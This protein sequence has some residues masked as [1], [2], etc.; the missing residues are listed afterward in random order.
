MYKLFYKISIY[1]DDILNRGISIYK[2]ILGSCLMLLDTP[3]MFLEEFK[4]DKN[5][6]VAITTDGS[7]NIKAAA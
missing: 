6:I 3:Y 4:I 5:K 2:F 7:A 1:I